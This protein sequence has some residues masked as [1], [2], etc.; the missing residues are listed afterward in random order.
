MFM[1]EAES[2]SRAGSEELSVWKEDVESVTTWAGVRVE[3]VERTR[4]RGRSNI[5]A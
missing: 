1:K 3:K 5:V 4:V 2:G